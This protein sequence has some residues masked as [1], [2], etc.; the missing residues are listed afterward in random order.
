MATGGAADFVEAFLEATKCDLDSPVTSNYGRKIVEYRDKAQV[1]AD[2]LDGDT[3]SLVRVRKAAKELHET[4]LLLQRQE[5]ELAAATREVAE[6]RAARAVD[7]SESEVGAALL[8][9]SMLI[10]ELA[11]LTTGLT[12]N[13]H[14][15]LVHPMDVLLK[16]DF[17]SKMDLKKSVDKAVKDYETRFGKIER[18]VRLQNKMSGYTRSALSHS[19]L[20]EQLSK[21]RTCV[22]YELCKFLLTVGAIEDKKG[23]DLLRHFIDFFRSQ[24]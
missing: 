19:E 5:R 15:H 2:T 12:R 10:S 18:D 8:K 1:M 20:S 14:N 24:E 6:Y 16:D 11:L 22:Q 13:V 7:D 17:R 4:T 21:E 9:F 3:A 23:P